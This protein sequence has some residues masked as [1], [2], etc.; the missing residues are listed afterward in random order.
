SLLACLSGL[1]LLGYAALGER[2]GLWALV[3]GLLCFVSVTGLLGANWIASLL[4]LYPGQAGA[5]SAVA[6][7]G[8]FG[9]GCLASLAVGWLALPCVLPMALV[10][11]VCGVGSLLA[12]GLALHGGNR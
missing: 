4:A 2:G 10:M 9:L 12:L 8:Q 1:F 6:V 3:P 7:S 5:A 11:A